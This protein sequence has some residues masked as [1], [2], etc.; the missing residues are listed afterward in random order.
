[1]TAMPVSYHKQLLGEL[2]KRKSQN[3]AYSLRAFSRA[4]GLSP[5]FLSKLLRK[6]KGLSLFRA[7]SICQKLGYGPIQTKEFCELVTQA[8]SKKDNFSNLQT[9]ELDHFQLVADWYHGAIIEL[10][11]LK[12]NKS[13]TE[14]MA[15]E[16]GVSTEQ[17]QEALER[18]I[19]LG[20]VKKSGDQYVKSR[21]AYSTPNDIPNSAIRF[22]H[23]QMLAKASEALLRQSVSERHFTGH[24][25]AVK[26]NK[27]SQAKS[28]VKRFVTRMSKLMATN[29]G[30][31]VYQ[32]NV[33]LF[34]LSGDKDE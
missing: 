5:A 20:L 12:K 11:D 24:T 32:L 28:E 7:K 8:E 33:Q 22:Y 23:Q 26:K 1:M 10:F 34:S 18:L 3:P 4:L 30:D 17:A 15:R 16:L 13:S 2:E 31:K 14:W 25:F 6:E 19:R 21:A 9:L 27:L 29:E